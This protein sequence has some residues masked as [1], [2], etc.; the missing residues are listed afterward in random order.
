ML[1]YSNLESFKNPIIAGIEV[2]DRKYWKELQYDEIELYCKLL[3]IDG[4]DD[5]V[6]LTMQEYKKYFNY[7]NGD[8]IRVNDIVYMLMDSVA[9]NEARWVAS[10][11][12]KKC[13]LIPVRYEN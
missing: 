12:V 6:M 9:G 1:S 10:H 13:L 7:D 11:S 4:K 2:A 8:M 5:W 3:V